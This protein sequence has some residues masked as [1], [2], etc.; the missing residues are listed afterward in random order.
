MHWRL[1]IAFLLTTNC[2]AVITA[3]PPTHLRV[4]PIRE[5]PDGALVILSD[6]EEM[7]TGA[8]GA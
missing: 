8:V 4:V 5:D 6:S 2:A 3:T 1:R 7:D